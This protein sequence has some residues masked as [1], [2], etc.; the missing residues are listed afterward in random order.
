MKPYF[1]VCKLGWGLYLVSFTL[2]SQLPGVAWT[3]T[4]RQ[5]LIFLPRVTV[6][7]DK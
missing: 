7:P 4:V 5:G 1:R 3:A 2:F 6:Q